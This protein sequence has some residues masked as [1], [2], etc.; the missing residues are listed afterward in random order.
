MQVL[1]PESARMTSGR[2]P[3]TSPWPPMIEIAGP[4]AMMRGPGNSPS[5]V[6]RAK[7]KPTCG[8]EPRSRTVVKPARSVPQR[9]ANP[10]AE[11][12]IRRCR[13]PPRDSRRRDCR[14]DGRA[15]RSGPGSTVLPERSI[16]R[17]PG[18]GGFRPAATLWM[19]PSTMVMVE[20]PCAGRDGSAISRPAWTTRVSAAAGPATNSSS[21]ASRRASIGESPDRARFM[22]QRRRP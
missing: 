7:A 22:R 3:V 18:G 9:V 13:P 20:G 21:A 17:A 16:S 15:C 10:H 6:P 14:R 8:P 1:P 2:K 12:H 11:P 19:R 5:L 4:E